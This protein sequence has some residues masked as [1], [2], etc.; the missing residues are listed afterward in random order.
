MPIVWDSLVCL[1]WFVKR[2][3]V[4]GFICLYDCLG[5]VYV[6][7]GLAAIIMERGIGIVYILVPIDI[8]GT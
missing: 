6:C 5:G 4:G 2:V 1:F 8:Q 3:F 7:L